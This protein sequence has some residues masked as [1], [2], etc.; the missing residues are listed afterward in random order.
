MGVTWVVA[1]GEGVMGVPEASARELVELFS[2]LQSILL[3]QDTAPTTVDQLA[4]LARHLIPGAEGAGVVLLEPGGGEITTTATDAVLAAAE[5]LEHALDEGPCY[6]AWATGRTERVEDTAT[7]IRWPAWSPAARQLGIRSMLATPLMFGA[8]ALGVVEVYATTPHAF[9]AA[10]ERTM[11]L[12]AAAV[13]ALLG[14][15]QATGA[16]PRISDA[17]RTVFT[18]RQALDTA[19]G[20]LM[21]RHRLTRPAAQRLLAEAAHAHHRSL[22]ETAQSIVESLADP[23]G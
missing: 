5:D 8:E 7:D 3:G 2:R 15:G 16:A 1:S 22:A 10:D 14:S 13:A 23:A 17:L 12:L 9:T 21:E 18:D 4:Q 6:S 19:T 11:G 20:I